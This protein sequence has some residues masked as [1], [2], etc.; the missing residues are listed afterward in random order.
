[1]T[2]WRVDFSKIPKRKAVVHCETKEQ[3]EIFY[4]AIEGSYPK[5][6]RTWTGN[7]WSNYKEE[8]CYNPRLYSD[9]D[10]MTYGDIEC[11]EDDGYLIIDFNDIA[12]FI[13]DLPIESSD[14]SIKSLFGME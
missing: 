8:T 12:E 11:Y 7:N 5:K 14:I 6:L 3:A 13:S 2:G 4:R 10:G 9:T 1:M